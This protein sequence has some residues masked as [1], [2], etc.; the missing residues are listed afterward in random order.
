MQQAGVLSGKTNNRF[1]PAGTATRAEVATVLRRFVEIVIDPQTANGWQQNDSGEWSYYKN[2]E[3][4]KGWL[5]NDQKWYWLDK[6][7]GK[8]FTGGWKQIDGKQYYFYA[9]GS[10]AVN[11]AIDGKTVGADGARVK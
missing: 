10:M 5:S 1:D 3:P 2:G 9:D 8:M 11:T 4:V 6:N 7:T